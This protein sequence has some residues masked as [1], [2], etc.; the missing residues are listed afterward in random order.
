MGNGFCG[1]IVQTPLAAS[2]PGSDVG[3]LKV[4]ESGLEFL[5]AWLIA[6]LSEPGPESFVFDT[7]IDPSS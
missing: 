7:I 2:K 5:F 6:S 3:I 1:F 4:M